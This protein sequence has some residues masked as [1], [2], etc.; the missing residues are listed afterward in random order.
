MPADCATESAAACSDPFPLAWESLHQRWSTS[1][2]RGLDNRYWHSQ[3][4]PTWGRYGWDGPIS[5]LSTF[6]GTPGEQGGAYIGT[7]T[8]DTIL[9]SAGMPLTGCPRRG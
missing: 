6:N 4:E 2:N 3:S 5:R 1:N 8:R 9:A 7:A